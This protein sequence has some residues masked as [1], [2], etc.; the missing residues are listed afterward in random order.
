MIT[1]ALSLS[2]DPQA[3]SAQDTPSG[4]ARTLQDKHTHTLF[5]QGLDLPHSISLDYGREPKYSDTFMQPIGTCSINTHVFNYYG[6]NTLKESGE[7]N[8]PQVHNSRNASFM[9]FMIHFMTADP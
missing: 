3:S 2:R 7:I 9:N 4:D 5:G 1:V 6:I 8:T